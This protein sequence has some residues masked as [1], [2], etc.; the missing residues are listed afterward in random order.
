MVR[1]WKRD[2][3]GKRRVFWPFCT[4]VRRGY[5]GFVHVV[6]GAWCAPGVC[7]GGISR[8]M[9][10]RARWSNWPF[11]FP[12]TAS[13]AA[14]A[15]RAK[16][17][18]NTSGAPLARRNGQS[19]PGAFGLIPGKKRSAALQVS[20]AGRSWSLNPLTQLA[21]TAQCCRSWIMQ[22]RSGSSH[23]RQNTPEHPE[24]IP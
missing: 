8:C 19:L 3:A 22:R 7:W 16:G 2:R 9:C 11:A 5:G 15:R 14:T 10:V 4:G 18:P 21:G 24:Q 1:A 12:R 6:L 17:A 13:R 23:Y 20:F